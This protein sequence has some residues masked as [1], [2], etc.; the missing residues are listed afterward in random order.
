MAQQIP[1]T[2]IKSVQ[3]SILSPQEIKDLSVVKVEKHDT[4]EGGRPITNGLFDQRMGTL[5]TN[6]KC[7]TCH[8]YCQDCPGH[9]GH[10]ELV[11]PVFNI[12]YMNRIKK[13]LQLISTYLIIITIPRLIK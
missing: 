4:Y 8:Q 12:E 11:K 7:L 5:E 10:I 3:F 2:R 1:F 6:E 9:F 13:T